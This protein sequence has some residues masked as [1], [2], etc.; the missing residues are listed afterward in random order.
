MAINSKLQDRLGAI[1][2][3]YVETIKPVDE[4]TLDEWLRAA[5]WWAIRGRASLA[6]TQY[7]DDSYLACS[8]DGANSKTIF[9]G[10]TDMG[11][12]WWICHEVIAQD[13]FKVMTSDLRIKSTPRGALLDQYRCVVRYLRPYSHQLE[14]TL[15]GRVDPAAMIDI[16]RCLWV[17]YAPVAPY[18][19]TILDDQRLAAWSIPLAFG[20]TDDLFCYSSELVQV[21]LFSQEEYSL[22]HSF[23]C[24]LSIVRTRS[25]WETLGVIAS[26]TQLIH[27]TVQS[28]RKQGPTWKDIEW[29][30]G[31]LS[32]LVKLHR[33]FFLDVK[34]TEDSFKHIWEAVHDIVLTEGVMVAGPDEEIIFDDTIKA[35]HYINHDKPIDFPARPT[36]ECRV[37][38][39]KESTTVT[40]GPNKRRSHRGYRVF[41]STPPQMKEMHQ[42]SH[43]LNNSSPVVYSLL[44]AEDGSPGIFLHVFDDGQKRSIFLYFHHP[45]SRT[46]LHSLLVDLIP[47][48]GEVAL[49]TFPISSF[50]MLERQTREPGSQG[51]RH[52]EFGESLA[53]VIEQAEE[54]ETTTNPYGKTTLS[55]NLRIVVETDWGSMTDRLNIGACITDHILN[56][57]L[58]YSIIRTRRAGHRTIS[59]GQYHPPSTSVTPGRPHH[60]RRPGP[61][62]WRPPNESLKRS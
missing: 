11:K 6:R 28:N 32:M 43:F 17:F 53:S 18:D 23:P 41:I 10:L 24:V 56:T 31:R 46:L 50:V 42:V 22:T 36:A 44:D 51:A 52:L 27:V 57:Y 30:V 13:N 40:A 39:L 29:D 38:L 5:V 2:Q 48:P 35:C 15:L 45:E 55:E 62:Q 58:T 9:Q 54:P 47:G 20:D 61:G 16:D 12:A 33:G 3:P 8:E 25:S 14:T 59:L 37:R 7:V 60:D 49:Q 1:F 19:V 34:F 26:Q 21:T 4:I